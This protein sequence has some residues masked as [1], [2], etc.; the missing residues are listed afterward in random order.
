MSAATPLFDRYAPDDPC[1]KRS[2]GSLESEQAFEN[3]R[4]HSET[5]RL[6]ILDFVTGEGAFGATVE[7]IS[8]ALG[9]RMTTVSARVSELKH[10][11]DGRLVKSGARR[12]TT[13]GSAAAVVVARV[14]AP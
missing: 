11:T 7:E 4:G 9:M 13:S 3:A 2:R 6:R 8:L 12:A 10:A 1:A 14:F 5:D